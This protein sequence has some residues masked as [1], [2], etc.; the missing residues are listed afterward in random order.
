[1]LFRN[2]LVKAALYRIHKYVTHTSAYTKETTIRSNIHNHKTDR[3]IHTRVDKN[4]EAL[5]QTKITDQHT[6]KHLH[7]SIHTYT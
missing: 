5:T 2:W 4:T 3:Y 7:K 1:M 6:H